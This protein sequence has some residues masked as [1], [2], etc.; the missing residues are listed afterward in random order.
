MSVRTADTTVHRARRRAMRDYRLCS[1]SDASRRHPSPWFPASLWRRRRSWG[2]AQECEGRPAD[3]AWGWTI[4]RLAESV[5]TSN[6]LPVYIELL[7]RIHRTTYPFG[8][9]QTPTRFSHESLVSAW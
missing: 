2:T 5:N 9:R 3:R 1:T 6:Y 7:T 4:E 8:V